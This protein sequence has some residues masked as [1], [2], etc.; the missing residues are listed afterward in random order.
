MEVDSQEVKLALQQK[1]AE[2]VKVAITDLDGVLRGKYMHVDKFLK[3]NKPQ[4][5]VF[6]NNASELN[7]KN[8]V[9]KRDTLETSSYTRFKFGKDVQKEIKRQR[10]EVRP[11]LIKESICGILKDEIIGALEKISRVL[12]NASDSSDIAK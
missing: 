6:A 11:D 1:G 3:S 7:F 9:W 5:I 2:Y 4:N 12:E 8:R 10:K